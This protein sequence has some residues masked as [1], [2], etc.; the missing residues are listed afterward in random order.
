MAPCSF[1]VFFGDKFRNIRKMFNPKRHNFMK[2]RLEIKKMLQDYFKESLQSARV[3]TNGKETFVYIEYEDF[4]SV[5]RVTE[6]LQKKLPHARVTVK[7]TCSDSMMADILLFIYGY[8]RGTYEGKNTFDF[9][10]VSLHDL[11]DGFE[12]G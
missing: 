3:F 11:M 12:K 2:T 4:M 5:R 7:R 9:L 8:G 1:T 10:S 6:E